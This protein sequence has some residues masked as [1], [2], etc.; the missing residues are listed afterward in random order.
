M[1]W[2]VNFGGTRVATVGE[3]ELGELQDKLLRVASGGEAAVLIELEDDGRAVK[4]LYTV[5]VPL[6]L[7]RETE[8]RV[9]I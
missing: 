6:Y 9:Y 2:H 3:E 4:L 7:E 5:G 1:R 8:D